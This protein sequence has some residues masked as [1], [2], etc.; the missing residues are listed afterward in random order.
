MTELT[1]NFMPP[2]GL[3]GLPHGSEYIV[4]IVIAILLFGTRLPKIARSIGASIVEFKKGVKGVQD[5]IDTQSTTDANKKSEARRDEPKRIIDASGSEIRSEARTE[6][7]ET[8]RETTSS[9]S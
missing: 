6:S 8:A 3:L 5:D 2:L 7:R 9:S 4:L 1:Q